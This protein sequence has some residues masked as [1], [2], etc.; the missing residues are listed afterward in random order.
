MTTLRSIIT[1]VLVAMSAFIVVLNWG[2]VI[3]NLQN[4]RKGIDQRH[5][6]IPLVSFV[7]ATIAFEVCPFTSKG[8]IGI[9]PLV[10]IG[11]WVLLRLPVVYWKGCR[12]KRAQ[13]QNRGRPS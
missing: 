3:I 5:S 7:L 2:Y 1:V 9:I 11:N 10:D 12:E 6:T 8:W 4:K 13:D